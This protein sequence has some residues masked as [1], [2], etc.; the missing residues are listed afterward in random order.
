MQSSVK[1]K[2]SWINFV[3]QAEIIRLDFQLI[4]RSVVQFQGY[5]L[6]DIVLITFPNE[7]RVI[8]HGGRF[9]TQ[10][11][12]CPGITWKWN[13]GMCDSS[14]N[15]TF[16]LSIWLQFWINKDFGNVIKSTP[17]CCKISIVFSLSPTL[18]NLTMPCKK[19]NEQC[20]ILD[21]ISIFGNK[22]IG[23]LQRGAE[24][25]SKYKRKKDSIERKSEG[26]KLRTTGFAFKFK[27]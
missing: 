7:Q 16:T 4:K 20:I 21:T 8:Q 17:C 14:L 24:N 3:I 11:D 27:S 12:H 25:R 10:S 23:C 15:I 26:I 2:Q 22:L 5:Y 1:P 18:S 13:V 6:L 9:V 19:L